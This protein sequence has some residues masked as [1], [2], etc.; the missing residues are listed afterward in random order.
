MSD[1][2]DTAREDYLRE[3]LKERYGVHLESMER[4]DRGVVRVQLQDGR[5]WI[6]RVFPKDR[7]LEQVEGDAAF[8]QFL[9]RRGF[10]A[11]RCADAHPVSVLYG[12]GILVTEYIEGASV[13]PDER[14]LSAIGEMLGRLNNL[15]AEDGPVSRE[16]GALHHYARGGGGPASELAA[17]ASWLAAIEDRVP[18]EQR[19]R[20]EA[21]REQIAN[22]DT[23]QNLPQALIHPDPVLKNLLT[24]SSGELVFIDWAGAGRGPRL[25]ALAMLIWSSAF[26]GGGWSRQRIDAVVAGYREHIRLEEDELARL[27]AVMRIRPLVF[28]CWRYRHAVLADKVPDGSEWWWPSDRLVQ[29]IAAAARAAFQR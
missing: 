23:C 4:L 25:S 12:R 20:Y 19:A 11:E 9:E 8:L 15:P 29:A 5:R 21:L 2:Q 26:Q 28:A 6:A 3:H 18:A 14:A 16:A 22:A 24:T 17:A 1:I 10:R 27:A 13:D 7:P